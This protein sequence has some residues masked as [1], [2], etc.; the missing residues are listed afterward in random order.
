MST[1]VVVK[2]SLGSTERTGIWRT[3]YICS[4]SGVRIGLWKLTASFIK[5][6]SVLI[7]FKA[8]RVVLNRLGHDSHPIN[9]YQLLLLYLWFN[10]SL[11]SQTFSCIMWSFCLKLIQPRLFTKGTKKK[12][13]NNRTRTMVGITFHYLK[14]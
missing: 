12:K 11:Y 14:S 5:G 3:R 9:I 10:E 6:T 13:I 8:A 4:S 2:V 7:D 1:E